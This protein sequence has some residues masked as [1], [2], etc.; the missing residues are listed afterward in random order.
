MKVQDIEAIELDLFIEALRKRYSYDFSSYA[1]ASFK[2]R[3][4]YQVEKKNLSKISEL[5]VQLLYDESFFDEFLKEM[6]VTVTEMFRDPLVFKAIRE[7][8][9]PVLKTYPS[10]N[11]WHAGCATGEEAYSMAIVLKEEGLLG[12]TRLYA[13]DFNDH[14]LE[15][16]RKGI[17][18]IDKMKLFIDNYIASG[19]KEPF[20]DYYHAEYNFVKMDQSLIKNIT[21]ANHNLMGD[22]R[23][24]EMHVILCR[25]VLIYFNRELQNRVLNLFNE[26]LVYRGFLVLGDKESLDLTSAGDY[27]DE[28]N[29]KRHIFRIKR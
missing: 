15:M 13:T 6:S 3:V 10:I 7:E 9:I 21:F 8:L 23:F 20:S 25:N 12:K 11:I 4:L 28:F 1:K 2:R 18:P 19:G 26:S 29:R 27:F 24:A 5:Q 14:S 16:A 22:Q 17:Y